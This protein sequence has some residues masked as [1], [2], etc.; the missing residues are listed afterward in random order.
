MENGIIEAHT[1]AEMTDC[2]SPAPASVVI[3]GRASKAR[4][5]SDIPPT[6]R[7]GYL[8]ISLLTPTAAQHSSCWQG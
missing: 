3:A 6:R 8:N 7:G 5:F 2:I 4:K 1:T